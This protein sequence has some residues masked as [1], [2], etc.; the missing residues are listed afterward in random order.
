MTSGQ[1]TDCCFLYIIVL[2]FFILPILYFF[3]EVL[4]FHISLL[5]LMMHFERATKPLGEK[6][7][8]GNSV[9]E[10][11]LTARRI[12][13]PEMMVKERKTEKN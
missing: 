2:D 9:S 12:W 1:R 8:T 4:I 10:I 13:N 7:N 6:K 11:S 5:L 3:L